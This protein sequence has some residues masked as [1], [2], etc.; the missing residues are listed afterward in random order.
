MESVNTKLPKYLVIAEE[1][2]RRIKGGSYIPGVKLPTIR[3]MAVDFNVSY[4]TASSAVSYLEK[5]GFVSKRQG[6]GIVVNKLE[7]KSIRSY[8]GFFMPT[9]GHVYSTLSA[10]IIDRLNRNDIFS[11]PLFALG[12]QPGSDIKEDEAH[13]REYAQMDL[14]SVIISGTRLF[15]FKCYRKQCSR[16]PQTIFV[17]H[18]ESAIS[19]PDACRV[20]VDHRHGGRI[21][22]AA[23]IESGWDNLAVLTYSEMN[24][25]ELKLRGASAISDDCH[26][27]EGVKDA[28][29]E[30]DLDPES[31]TVIRNLRLPDGSIDTR[32]S[33]IETLLAD[34]RRGILCFGDHRAQRVYELA[35][36]TGQTPGVDFGICG[37]YDTPWSDML[38]PKLSSVS[39]KIEEI[40]N[41]VFKL[42][43]SGATGKDV[44]ITPEFIARESSQPNLKME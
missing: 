39:I 26:Y 27:I 36:K 18:L 22:A 33:S 19:F 31:L 42:V 14:R 6:S 35:R 13:I 5:E 30:H 40:S 24:T 4:L 15:P 3:D 32:E 16:I 23:M 21:S 17:L 1:I 11:L 37:Y 2:V 28:L 41:A 29:R 7:D 38:H 20:L 10:G 8:A 44:V 25:T 34:Q 43:T 12:I 9:T